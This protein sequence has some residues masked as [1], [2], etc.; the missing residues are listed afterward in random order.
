MY[1]VERLVPGIVQ[2]P[3]QF[4]FEFTFKSS[5][6]LKFNEIPRKY[7]PPGNET[8]WECAPPGNKTSRSVL[9]PGSDS[10][11]GAY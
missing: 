5:K 3:P 11:G 2:P 6:L 7:A 4:F 10:L 8:P 1:Y 9:L